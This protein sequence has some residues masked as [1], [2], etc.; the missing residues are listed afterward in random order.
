MDWREGC[1]FLAL[2]YH[3]AVHHYKMS[4]NFLCCF[5]IQ[6]WLPGVFANSL[7][8]SRNQKHIFLS[9]FTTVCR[10]CST[11]INRFIITEIIT[12]VISAVFPVL[13]GVLKQK[14][15]YFL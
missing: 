4:L 1:N 8:A 12:M 15:C 3:D 14:I 9:D 13:Q 6:D 11:E 10:S 7:K 2:R 5:N